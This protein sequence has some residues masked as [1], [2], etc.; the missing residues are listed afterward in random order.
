MS[1]K[2]ADESEIGLTVVQRR[3]CLSFCATVLVGVLLCAAYLVGRVSRSAPSAKTS[4]FSAKAGSE[5]SSERNPQVNFQPAA[6]PSQAAPA[7]STQV[8]SLNTRPG[9]EP[10]STA[11]LSRPGSRIP[12]DTYLQIAAV[13]RGMSEVLVEL[14]RRKGFQAEI[15]L[16]ATEDIFRVVVGPAKDAAALARIKADLQASGF[17]SF[18]RKTPKLIAN[19]HQ[20]EPDPGIPVGAT[21]DK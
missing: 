16:G 18:A 2:S 9:T 7:P 11:F 3:I 1:T 6:P 13:D 15:A 20:N 21:A 4:T 5:S 12:G 14:L 17:T 19:Q 8:Q 10:Q